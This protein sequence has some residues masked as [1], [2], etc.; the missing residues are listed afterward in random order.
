MATLTYSVGTASRDYSTIASWQSDTNDASH[1]GDI[2]KGETYDDTDFDED[3]GAWIVSNPTECQRYPATGEQ[4]DGTAGTGMRHLFSAN[5]SVLRTYS[6][7]DIELLYSGEEIH[8][9]G[10]HGDHIYNSIIHTDRNIS[11][12]IGQC[13]KIIAHDSEFPDNNSTNVLLAPENYH[14]SNCLFY[15]IEINTNNS[16]AISYAIFNWLELDLYNFTG[17]KSIATGLSAKAY[18][19]RGNTTG[20]I[21]YNTVATNATYE[22]IFNGGSDDEWR[23]C[24]E[25]DNSLSDAPSV[26]NQLN[27]SSNQYVSTVDGSEDY[28]PNS[29]SD[30]IN[31]G[32]DGGSSNG[33][34]EDLTGRDRHAEGDTWS[35]GAIQFTGTPSV[36]D[37]GI[38]KLISEKFRCIGVGG[39]LVR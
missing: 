17:D 15:D 13:N 22:A 18:G 29:S 2:V 33:I 32:V 9:N 36:P 14:W 26:T 28:A 30:L 24:L 23:Y 12:N 25:D 19:F 35:I 27:K 31:N 4:H 21:I 16:R 34:N 20:E 5:Q 8:L 7:T 10:Y 38:S 39:G 11:Y 6:G 37:E 1:S 3:I